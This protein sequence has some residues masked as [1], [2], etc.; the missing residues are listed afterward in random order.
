M[1][2]IALQF[3]VLET[4]VKLYHNRDENTPQQTSFVLNYTP[5]IIMKII[6]VLLKCDENN[7]LDCCETRWKYL[8]TDGCK[9]VSIN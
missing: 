7:K 3:N 2:P 4:P 1:L 6:L 9:N 5:T 8:Q